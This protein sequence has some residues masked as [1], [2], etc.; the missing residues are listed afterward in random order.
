MSYSK[1]YSGSV[2]YSGTVHYSASYGPSE[3]GG[4]VSGSVGYSGY[5]PVT[6]NLYVD[7]NPFDNS[8]AVACRPN[9]SGTTGSCVP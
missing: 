5:V 8:H 6:V 3:H 7:T 9:T 2:P 4:T 1:S